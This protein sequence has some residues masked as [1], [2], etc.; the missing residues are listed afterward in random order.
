MIH[1]TDMRD[2]YT[3]IYTCTH[4]HTHTHTH[5]YIN[6][7]YA[8]QRKWE[9]RNAQELENKSPGTAARRGGGRDLEDLRRIRLTFVEK[10]DKL[11]YD[12]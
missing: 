12:R 1:V 8:A 7:T 3:H 10:R 9:V 5:I 6:D 11:Q 4:T 2:S